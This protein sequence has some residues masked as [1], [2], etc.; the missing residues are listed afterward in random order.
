MNFLLAVF[1]GAVLGLVSLRLVGSTE[2]RY[3]WIAAVAFPV[4]AMVLSH[5]FPRAAA[6]AGLLLT[7]L[8]AGT[9]AC[10]R[11]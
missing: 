3:V 1:Q 6:A 2:L 11:L 9:G 7:L 5:L 4:G 10:Q 8:W